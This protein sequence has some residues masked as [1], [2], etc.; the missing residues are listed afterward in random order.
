LWCFAGPFALLDSAVRPRFVAIRLRRCAPR[1][2]PDLR[3]HAAALL[4][5][6]LVKVRNPV[7]GVRRRAP[8]KRME[9]AARDRAIGG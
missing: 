3:A 1:R 8:A 6:R 7:K 2:L 5:F 4:G 9:A